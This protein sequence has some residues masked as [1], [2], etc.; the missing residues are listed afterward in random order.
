MSAA[1]RG[2][3][4]ALR[5]PLMRAV[6]W[7]QE[8]LPDLTGGGFLEV[9]AGAPDAGLVDPLLRRRL[10]AV[11]RGMIH[12]AARASAGQG[13]L[14]SVFASQHGEPAR[15]LP[16][17]EDLAAGQDI[18]PTQFSMNVH[19]AVAGIWSIARQDPSAAT[20]VGSGSESFGWGLLEAFGLHAESGA[21]VLFIFGDDTLPALFASPSLRESPLH[22]AGLLLGLPASR[23]LRV[24]RGP[25]AGPSA[26]R[27]QS[28]HAL[29][30]LSGA[31]VGTWPG[32]RGAWTFSLE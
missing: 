12:C 5:I 22:A 29:L 6:A 25:S 18:S 8:P 24:E 14:R 19:N 17:L 15:T 16:M 7:S 32:P 30:A 9:A 2:A 11:G 26:I 10:S 31:A 1:G 4:N 20:A 27:S 23:W 13:P 3:G 28:L 21:P